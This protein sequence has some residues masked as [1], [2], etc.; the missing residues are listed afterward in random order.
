MNKDRRKRIEAL[1]E[2]IDDIKTEIEGIQSEE[3]DAFDNMPESFQDGERGEQSQS[4]IGA[5]GEALGALDETI[6]QLNTASE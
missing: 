2:K 4:A 1:I 3:Q 6:D 5:L